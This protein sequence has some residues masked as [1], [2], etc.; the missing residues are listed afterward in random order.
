MVNDQAMKHSH[1]Y[2]ALGGVV[3]AG[4]ARVGGAGLGN[5]LLSWARAAV[6]AHRLDVPMIAPVWT[7]LKIGPLLRGE[8]DAR[9][10]AK[11]FRAEPDALAGLAKVKAFAGSRRMV[12][13][14]DPE[15]VQASGPR[16]LYVPEPDRIAPE[17]FAGITGYRDLIVDRL[18]NM[19]RPEIFA[20]LSRLPA[21]DAAVHVRLGDFAPNPDGVLT[22]NTRL[23]LSWYANRMAAMR[24]ALGPDTC[25]TIFSDGS[26]EEL[27]PL[28]EQPG[29]T[30]QQGEIALVDIYSLARARALIGSFST[31]SMWAAYIGGMP[32]LW[33]PGSLGMPVTSD[34]GQH[35]LSGM[36][37]ALPPDFATRIAHHSVEHLPAA[38]RATCG[39]KS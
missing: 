24:T 26:P 17:Y 16:T 31:F 13:F 5:L 34:P 36:D 30:L 15:L 18:M 6:L 22:A 12:R 23:P 10:Y 2:P 8:R 25:F 35:L 11:L 4:F 27:A 21:A 3:D 1:V 28:L 29:V 19:T 33:H 9:I 14:V 39:H 32:A 37:E 38:L 7:T 20:R